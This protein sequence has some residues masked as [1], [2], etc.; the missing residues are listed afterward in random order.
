MSALLSD[1][2]YEVL[3]AE[4]GIRA[5]EV[6]DET[7]LDLV[8]TDMK[9]PQMDGIDLLTRI[10]KLRPE[11]P[12]IVMTAFGTVEKAV[13][14]MKT[15]AFDYITKPFQ[16]EELMLTIQK[17]LDMHRLVRVNRELTQELRQRDRFENIISKNRG[18]R[19]I[20]RLIEK[21]ADTQANVL[22]TGESGTGK[23][24]IA[25]AI[26]QGNRKRRNMPFVTINCV[27]LPETLLESELFGHEKGAFTGAVAS[28][29]G[30]FELSDR[31]TIFLDEI[32]DMSPPLQA[33]LLRV[34][35]ERE[36]ERV[37]GSKTIKVDVR[38][39][40]ASNQDLKQEVSA[41][42]FRE[43]LLYRLNV[44]H[45]HLPPLRER[46]D[47]IPLL[48][49]HF[50][51]LY[52]AK[53]GRADLKI[54]PESMRRIYSYHWPGNIRE[55]E[56]VIERAVIL[57]SGQEIGPDDL[58]PDLTAGPAEDVLDKDT[59]PPF[60]INAFIPSSVGLND[61]LETVEKKM[62]LRA[63]EMAENV[64]AH[65]AELLGIKKNVMQYKLKKYD[66]I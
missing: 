1:Q 4:N 65:A 52:E 44:V 11:L 59:G 7:D 64:Q 28:R 12:V 57:C 26:H 18:M 31:G 38:L 2:G 17:A 50:V 3:T 49:D 22:I 15:G 43:D 32:G 30:R 36:F 25:R 41:G 45:I 29:K 9:M 58:P 6:I 19:A 63:M 53:D 66:L 10:T 13:E 39:V 21:V 23:E 54:S 35:Q 27:A 33:K 55:L 16:N 60:D 56:N 20:F 40:A 37:G 8:L 5:L 46:A 62:I 47:D 42:R 14:A 51:R 24:L 34:I 61:A 48:V